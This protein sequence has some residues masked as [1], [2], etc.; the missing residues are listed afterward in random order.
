MEFFLIL[1]MENFRNRYR[2][3]IEW[4]TDGEASNFLT[5]PCSLISFPVHLSNQ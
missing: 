2:P 1:R 5:F 4:E 3:G